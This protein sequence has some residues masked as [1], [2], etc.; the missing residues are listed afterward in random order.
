MVLQRDDGNTMD[1]TR[2]QREIFKENG[3]KTDTYN[4]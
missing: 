4:Y 2:E 3:N 1:G